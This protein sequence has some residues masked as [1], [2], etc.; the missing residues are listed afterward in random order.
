ME[1]IITGVS[2]SVITL[3]ITMIV[4]YLK[5]RKSKDKQTLALLVKANW[6]TLC[7]LQRSGLVNG[8][9]DGV[10]DELENYLLKK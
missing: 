8:D 5:N 4:N 7:A 2:V 10:K 3:A 9:C 1:G 6:V